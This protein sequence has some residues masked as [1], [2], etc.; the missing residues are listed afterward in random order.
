[1][2]LLPLAASAFR[3]R[4]AMN[5]LRGG[6]EVALARVDRRGAPQA[7]RLPRRRHAARIRREAYMLAIK[8]IL[9]PTDFSDLG[10]IEFEKDR[11]VAELGS[12]F[13]ELVAL[14]IL[15]VRAKG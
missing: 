4:I 11:L 8:H 1:M 12:L 2:P 5:P 6:A 3:A 9:V 10:F 7:Q 13:K 15:E 14:D